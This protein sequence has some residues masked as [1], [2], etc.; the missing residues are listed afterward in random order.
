MTTRIAPALAVGAL[1]LGLSAAAPARAQ[2]ANRPS[3][4]FA[5]REAMPTYYDRQFAELDRRRLDDLTQ[6]AGKLKGAEAE[7]TYQELFNL[8]IARNLYDEADPAAG[9]VLRGGKVNALL[10]A[11]A[12]FVHVIAQAD[13]GKYD[14][15][16]QGL[17]QFLHSTTAEKD[18]DPTTIYAVGE[19]FLQRLIRA[20]RYDQARQVA[21]LFVEGTKDTAIRNHFTARIERLDRLGKPAPLIRGSDIDGRPV[22]LA[23]QK[24][25]VVL[26][27]FWATWCP[28]CVAEI[29]R[30]NALQAKYGDKGFAVL[31]VNLDAAHPQVKDANRAIPIVR[32]FLVNFRVTWPTVLNGSGSEDFARAYGV[33]EIPAN[34]LIDRDGKIVHVELS[35]EELEKVV[36]EAV[37][38]KDQKGERRSE[39]SERR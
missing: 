11:L 34:F 3:G 10:R 22:S 18:V 38:A 23:D 30:I 4:G 39:G 7:A 19:A 24:G 33:T 27:D 20:G 35:G 17:R 9:Q 28:P 6:L 29:P 15:A 8:A 1:G 2:E 36:A 25:K 21:Q 26:V 14:D 5:S 12:T 16:L 37:G 32:R 13:G 31:G